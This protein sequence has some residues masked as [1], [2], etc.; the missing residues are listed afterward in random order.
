MLHADPFKRGRNPVPLHYDFSYDYYPTAYYRPGP[1]VRV[2]R[3]HN[4]R[5]QYHKVPVFPVGTS[6]PAQVGASGPSVRLL[7]GRDR[8]DQPAPVQLEQPDRVE[9]PAVQGLALAWA[10]VGV[11]IFTK[12]TPTGAPLKCLDCARQWALAALGRVS[13]MP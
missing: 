2:Y 9:V 3:L 12:V 6:G 7:L 13:L 4:C 11:L 5:Q 1:D 10:A 8:V